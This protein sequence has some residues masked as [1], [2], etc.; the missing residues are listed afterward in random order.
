MLD[1]AELAEVAGRFGVADDQVVRDHF[2]SHILRG[3]ADVKQ[4]G[5]VFFGGT[6]LARTYLPDGRLSEDID[7]YTPNRAATA[8][9]LERRL[10]QLVSREFPRTHWLIPLTGVRDVE[11]AILRAGDGTGIRIQLLSA[12]GM[13]GWPTEFRPLDVRYSDVGH[14]ALPVPTLSAFTAMKTTAWADRHAER[15]L[16]DL[17]AL[18]EIGAI[19]EAAASLVAQATGVR[20]GPYM[21]D[22]LPAGMRWQEQLAHQ[23]R[24]LPDPHRCLQRVRA[25]YATAL[26]WHT[27]D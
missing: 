12:E 18:A 15:D 17:N 27:S 4:D 19:N 13:F 7:L 16:Y 1:P 23:L 24:K 2:I 6:A 9:V 11:A 8:A 21:F 26:G 10:P 25:A 20:V 14:A 22:H 3:L 5:L